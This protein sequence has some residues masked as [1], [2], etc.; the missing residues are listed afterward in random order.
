M[1]LIAALVIAP[2]FVVV[3]LSFAVALGHNPR[4]YGVS[5]LV[6][7]IVVVTPL[8]Y[9]SLL[10]PAIDDARMRTARRCVNISVVTFLVLSVGTM[11]LGVE[12][13]IEKVPTK[14]PAIQ[15]VVNSPRPGLYDPRGF[16]MPGTG[17]SSAVTSSTGSLPAK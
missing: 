1:L 13:V 11:M 15:D 9:V 14:T 5:G 2:A 3:L 4:A 12:L 8:F 16:Q 10:P 17:S 6:L 7:A